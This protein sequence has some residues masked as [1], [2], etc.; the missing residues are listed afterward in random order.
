MVQIV[1]RLAHIVTASKRIICAAGSIKISAIASKQFSRGKF[2][3]AVAVPDRRI[4]NSQLARTGKGVITGPQ[5][6]KC[7]SART[8]E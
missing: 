6:T 1:P 5:V 3:L 4:I 7:M 8:A 2:R